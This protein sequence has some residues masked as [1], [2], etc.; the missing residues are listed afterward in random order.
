MRHPLNLH[1]L[2]SSVQCDRLMSVVIDENLIE[3]CILGISFDQFLEVLIHLL[4]S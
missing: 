3:G 4:K 1:F 2:Q